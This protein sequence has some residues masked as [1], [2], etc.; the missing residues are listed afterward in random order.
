MGWR[1]EAGKWIKKKERNRAKE[2]KNGKVALS[3]C[4][5]KAVVIVCRSS[6]GDPREASLTRV[7]ARHPHTLT[8][9]PEY[10]REATL[11]QGKGSIDA[12][13]HFRLGLCNARPPHH[14]S[15]GFSA[16]SDQRF[17]PLHI[18]L[19]LKGWQEWICRNIDS[20]SLRT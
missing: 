20:L 4:V 18:P 14:P 15:R 13:D 1:R 5:H 12:G 16:A 6:V 9:P 11:S 19:R 7:M 8:G 2:K 3:D 17:I 10:K